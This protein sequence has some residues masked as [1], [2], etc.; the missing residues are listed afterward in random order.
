MKKVLASLICMVEDLCRRKVNRTENI[1][2]IRQPHEVIAEMFRRLPFLLHVFHSNAHT[3]I[4]CTITF[5]TFFL[6][7]NNIKKKAKLVFMTDLIGIKHCRA[8]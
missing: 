1:S 4:A 3:A 8:D 6:C 5:D 2:D 7:K